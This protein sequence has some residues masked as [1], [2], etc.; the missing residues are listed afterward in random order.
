ML[1]DLSARIST[2]KVALSLLAR[3]ADPRPRADFVEILSRHF[4]TLES[5]VQFGDIFAEFLG[6]CGDACNSPGSAIHTAMEE[7]K[8]GYDKRRLRHRDMVRTLRLQ[9]WSNEQKV[10]FLKKTTR[11]IHV[12]PL[13]QAYPPYKHWVYES[14]TIER[15]WR[16]H[17]EEGAQPDKRQPRLPLHHEDVSRLSHIIGE[18]D[19]VT[20]RDAHTGEIVAV[21]IRN[22]CEDEE[23]LS[24]A[25]GVVEDVIGLKKSVR[26]SSTHFINAAGA[27]LRPV[28]RRPW[29]VGHRWLYRWFPQP[30]SV[31]L[32]S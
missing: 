28:E 20:I 1:S 18:D 7:R 30:A 10:E 3:S 19:S 14:K 8:D 13:K 31:R 17:I 25:N 21:V 26:V 29:Q 27:E 16:R 5:A 11:E 15:R 24:W 2:D 22:F 32:G 9:R 4:A 6:W 12:S 23:I